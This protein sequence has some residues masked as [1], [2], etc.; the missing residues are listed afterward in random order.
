[1][2]ESSPLLVL[3]DCKCEYSPR[4]SRPWITDSNDAV[5]HV[6]NVDK[7]IS[8]T[9]KNQEIS[10]LSLILKSLARIII[11]F[12]V[13]HNPARTELALRI[14]MILFQIQPI[15]KIVIQV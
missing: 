11:F 14:V 6:P 1:M 8:I 2:V 7:Q 15:K 5:L 3:C 4:T 9:A 12:E 13:L 10:M